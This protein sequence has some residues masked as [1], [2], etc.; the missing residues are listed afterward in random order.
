[1]EGFAF[2]LLNDPRLTARRPTTT[3]LKDLHSL[4]SAPLHAHAQSHHHPHDSPTKSLGAMSSTSS[5]DSK[6]QPALH[7]PPSASTTKDYL[8]SPLTLRNGRR[9][10]RDPT[11]T[12]PF[13]CDLAEIHRQSLRTLLLRQVFGAPFCNPFFSEG[14]PK[15]VLD[16]CCGSGLWT[17][18]CHQQFVR[19]GHDNVQFTGIDLVP[20]APD[21]SQQ[22]IN[23]HFVQ[24]DIRKKPLPFPAEHFDFIFIKDTS[25][26]NPATH[27]QGDPL[28]EPLRLLKPGGT[29]E[30]WD[31]DYIF[32]TLLPNPPAAPGITDEDQDHAD[33]TATYTV[34]PGTPFTKAQNTYLQDYNAWAQRAFEKRRLTGIPCAFIG[35]AFSAESESFQAG[36]ARRIAIPLGEVRW[37]REG[38]GGPRPKKAGASRRSSTSEEHDKEKDK[39]SPER[40]KNPD[41][42]VLN[43]EQGALR[44]TALLTIVQMIESLEP[45]LMEA[46]G[47]S[48]DEWDRWWAGMTHDLLQAKG[49]NNGE[50]LEVG[51]WWGKKR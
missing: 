26:C 20:L 45:M 44:Q 39:E 28:E 23:W 19:E 3:P 9:Y 1:M 32:R 29:L 48:R 18:I 13:P 47:K 8:T 10:I 16:M 15:R 12:Y 33:S 38:V 17:T 27:M 46:S 41:R 31:S 40:K 30:I 49:A 14:P 22:G 6:Q 51:A 42:K 25:L 7:H 35:L 2:H 43:S 21:L 4:I 37:E 36:G 11:S 24:H 5:S 50:C 34:S